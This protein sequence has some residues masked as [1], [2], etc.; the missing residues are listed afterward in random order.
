MKIRITNR[1]LLRSL[2]RVNGRKNE[3]AV[4]AKC[5]V[6]LLEKMISVQGRKAPK[7]ETRV[8]L[9][10]FLEVEMDDL[11]PW[12]DATDTANQAS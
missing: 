1:E 5:S 2:L 7:E 8:P 4:A 3:A 10:T 6:N 9:C 12:I 11:F